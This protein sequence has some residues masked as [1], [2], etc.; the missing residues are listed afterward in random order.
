[1]RVHPRR[2]SRIRESWPPKAIRFGIP[3]LFLF[4]SSSYARSPAWMQDHPHDVNDLL[5]IQQ[6]VQ[7]LL[8]GA[9][10]TVVSIVSE[11]GA[12]SGVVVSPEGLILSAAHVISARGLEMKIL[13]SDGSEAMAVSLG[14]SEIS[15]AGMLRMV[16]P[17]PWPHAPL[18]EHAGAKAGDWCFALGHPS[19]FDPERGM[20]A[21]IGRVLR[22]KDETLQSDC[23]LLGGDS[24][25]PLFDMDG[26]VIAIHSRISHGS[27][28]NFHVPIE[29]FLSNWEYFESMDL[30]TLESVMEGG[31]LG[32]ECEDSEVGL[33]ILDVVPGSAAA[34]SG[35]LQNDRLIRLNGQALDTREKLTILVSATPPGQTVVL[36]FIREEREISL[37]VELGTRPREMLP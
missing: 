37:R 23:K 20:V 27:E 30:L 32:V 36:D 8:P 19:G 17:G 31:F 13:F 34:E 12:G 21:R 33:I 28:E 15:D 7:T 6:R 4:L 24:G 26:K 9:E 14:G 18:R 1:M 2:L 25:G 11:D 35:L 10:K 3:A 22:R 29:S 5:E 16:D